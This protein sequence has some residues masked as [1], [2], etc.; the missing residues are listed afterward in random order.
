MG[1][2]TQVVWQSKDLNSRSQAPEPVVL[3]T[4]VD[5]FFQTAAWMRRQ[6][7]SLWL[8]VAKKT[9]QLEV[10]MVKIY[11]VKITQ[12]SGVHVSQ[13]KWNLGIGPTLWV[14]PPMIITTAAHL[15]L[16][17]QSICY[18][19]FWQLL[20]RRERTAYL[21]KMKRKV[22]YSGVHQEWHPTLVLLPG[23]SHGRR[24]LE[25]CSPWG[26]W[27]SDTN[28]RLHFHFHTRNSWLMRT[29]FGFGSRRKCFVTLN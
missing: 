8:T 11:K 4:I 16:N 12:V 6:S 26:C 24:S 25:G 10:G 17:F 27:G 1:K 9:L 7:R 29:F 22:L 23:K 20:L 3:T 18:T 21:V 2:T 5:W 19:F 15:R 14:V 28:E 13:G